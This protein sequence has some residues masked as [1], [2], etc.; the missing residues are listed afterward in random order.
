MPWAL[1]SRFIFIKTTLSVVGAG[2]MPKD[3][4]A[5]PAKICEK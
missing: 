1:R 4:F 5:G 3:S 2:F